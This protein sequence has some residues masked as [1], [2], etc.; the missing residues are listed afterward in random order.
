MDKEKK[1]NKKVSKKT[2]KT[3]REA[4]DKLRLALEYARGSMLNLGIYLT[5]YGKG[6]YDGVASVKRGRG[7]RRNNNGRNIF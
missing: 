7:K 1:M 6:F 4:N 2:I 5:W 3:I